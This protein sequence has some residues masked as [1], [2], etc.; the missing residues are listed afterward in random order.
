MES[1]LPIIIPVLN[2]PKLLKQTLESLA[3]N[4][5]FNFYPIIIDDGSEI[6]TAKY[7]EQLADNGAIHL[8]QNPA[9]IGVGLCRNLGA[10]IS[11]PTSPYLYFSDSDMYFTKNWDQ[12]LLETAQQ[13]QEIAILSGYQHPYHHTITSQKLSFSSRHELHLTHQQG[14]A[15]ML[16]RRELWNQIGP[17]IS[18][19]PGHTGGEDVVL[20]DKAKACGYQIAS[21]YPSVVIHAGITR[22]DGSKTAGAQHLM[23]QRQLYPHILFE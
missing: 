6:H 13:H 1:T 19:P 4:T 22:P 10:A 12:V 18:T 15:S 17:F 7:L 8:I 5:K 3:E 23:E 20:C 16:I 9:T 11:P 14:A 21:I 2:R